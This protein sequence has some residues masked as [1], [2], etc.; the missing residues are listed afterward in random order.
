MMHKIKIL[1]KAAWITLALTLLYIGAA[2]SWAVAACILMPLSL[3]LGIGRAKETWEF[4]RDEL[5]D[6]CP[7]PKEFFELAKEFWGNILRALK[8]KK[9]RGG[10]K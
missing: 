4:L 6:F 2:I 3:I 7:T 5:L 1:V 9:K 10:G 8:N